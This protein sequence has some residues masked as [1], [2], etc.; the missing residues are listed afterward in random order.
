M[1][2]VKEVSSIDFESSSEGSHDELVSHSHAIMNFFSQFPFHISPEYIDGFILPKYQT[3]NE[4]FASQ[5]LSLHAVILV[6]Q[7]NRANRLDDYEELENDMITYLGFIH[8]LKEFP[9]GPLGLKYFNPREFSD[10][11]CDQYFSLREKIGCFHR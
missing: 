2:T 3:V 4:I 10:Y 5:T 9:E 11:L 8:Y 7:I 1:S 6:M